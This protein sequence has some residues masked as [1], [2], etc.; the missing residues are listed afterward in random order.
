[1]RSG[2]GVGEDKGGGGRQRWGFI[3]KN[4]SWFLRAGGRGASGLGLS[5]PQLH[6]LLQAVQPVVRV[7]VVVLCR[8]DKG[9]TGWLV[10][11]LA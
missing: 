5:Q 3:R 10:A 11:W 2:W 8:E 4:K 6:Q 9:I 1:M 7:L